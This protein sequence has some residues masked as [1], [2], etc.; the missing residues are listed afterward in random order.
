MAARLGLRF[1]NC[2]TMRD[3]DTTSRATR[4]RAPIIA[5]LVELTSLDSTGSARSRRRVLGSSDLECRRRT[6]GGAEIVEDERST[7]RLRNGQGMGSR[8]VGVRISSGSK[9]A[10]AECDRVVH[11]EAGDG[12]GPAVLIVVLVEYLQLAAADA[13]EIEGVPST[14]ICVVSE[15]CCPTEEFEGADP[16]EPGDVQVSRRAVNCVGAT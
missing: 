1:L 4:E 13:L 15:R 3:D 10:R 11:G 9:D 8:I 7:S 16:V 2:A 6:G 14:E 12:K 5:V